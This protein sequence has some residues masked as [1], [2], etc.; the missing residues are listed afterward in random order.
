MRQVTGKE[1]AERLRRLRKDRKI[2]QNSLGGQ[3]GLS[4]KA[5]SKWENEGIIP[6]V[7]VLLRVAEALNVEIVDLIGEEVPDVPLE[8]RELVRHRKALWYRA[9]KR[10]HEIYGE[11]PPLPVVNRFY[12]EK[13]ILGFTNAAILFDIT[14]ELLL[15]AEKKGKR[16]EGRGNWYGSFAAWLLGASPVNPLP[17][18]YLCPRCKKVEFH[19]EE[20]SGWDLPE[21]QCECGE[22]MIRDGQA[23]PFEVCVCGTGTPFETMEISLPISFWEDAQKVI[24]RAAGP[25][26]S[27]RRHVEDTEDGRYAP[28]TSFFFE[29]KKD[30]KTPDYIEDIERVEELNNWGTSISYPA[31]RLFPLPDAKRTGR[32]PK[33]RT[34]ELN[35]LLR[36]EVLIRAL[37]RYNLLMEEEKEQ[38]GMDMTVRDPEKYRE[39]ITFGKLVSILCAMRNAYMAEN[40]ETMAEAVGLNLRE[41]PASWED[42]WKLVMSRAENPMEAGGLA[43]MI[44]L[45]CRNGQYIHGLKESDRE[46]FRQLNLPEW[47]PEY[48]QGIMTLD[49]RSRATITAYRLM[50]EVWQRMQVENNS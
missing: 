22:R 19:K 25:Y 38:T 40:P 7:E 48:S 20:L 44:V 24:L 15:E 10:L 43:G 11:R 30:E 18:H 2:T 29:A 17:A 13:S 41:M 27:L 50:E 46:L 45:N 21:K 36:E 16:I 14:H 5:V 12:Q 39:G 35:D 26:F 34:P 23:L 28:M 1:F 4:D 32:K 37:R 6:S 8:G 31:F 33:K 3:V 49:F 47:F 42:L 9:K